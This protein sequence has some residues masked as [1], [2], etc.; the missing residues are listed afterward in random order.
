MFKTGMSYKQIS[1]KPFS[2][3]E[4]TIVKVQLMKNTNFTL[5]SIYRLHLVPTN[6][7]LD[8]FTQLLEMLSASSEIFVL[9]GDINIH[10]D[11]DDSY[12]VRMKDIFSMFNL[13]QYVDIPTHKLRHT[14][15]C[16]LAASDC[17]Q[18]SE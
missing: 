9:S 16:V 14:I 17:P 2:S 1:C 12:A 4:H 15:D 3:F 5:I 13:K 18:I 6:V 7:F 11:E 8:E 10:L